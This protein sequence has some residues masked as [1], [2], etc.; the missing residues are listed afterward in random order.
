MEN[1]SAI[2]RY[3]EEHDLTLKQFGELIGVD[4]STVLRWERGHH[5]SRKRAL[6]IEAKTGIPRAALLLPEMFS[7]PAAPAAP[8]EPVAPAATVEA[9][10]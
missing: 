2:A 3:R 1:K 8:V 7:A 4:Q 10:E 5:M 9:A 6:E